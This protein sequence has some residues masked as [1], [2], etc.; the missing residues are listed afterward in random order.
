MN[1]QAY[2][3]HEDITPR[4]DV[5]PTG[6]IMNKIYD[7]IITHNKFSNATHHFFA[8]YLYTALKI[9]RN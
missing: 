1:N 6:T 9:S 4:G 8:V 7:L 2:R 3:R 5:K